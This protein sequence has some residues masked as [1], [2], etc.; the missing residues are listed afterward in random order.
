MDCYC[1]VAEIITGEQLVKLLKC[2]MAHL[3][4]NFSM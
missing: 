3:E 1:N 4:D 2:T